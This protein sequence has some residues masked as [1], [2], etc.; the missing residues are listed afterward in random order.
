MLGGDNALNVGCVLGSADDVRLYLNFY[1]STCRI[2][3]EEFRLTLLPRINGFIVD[4]HELDSSGICELVLF[5]VTN[6]PR[7]LKIVKILGYR[8]I[9]RR[10]AIDLAIGGH[11]LR[12]RYLQAFIL[13]YGSSHEHR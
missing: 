11:W 4:S 8:A 12:R 7:N 13:L 2:V 9:D 3:D 1:A 5:I 10:T 6:I